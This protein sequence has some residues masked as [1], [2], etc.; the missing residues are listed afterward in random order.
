MDVFNDE[1]YVEINMNGTNWI[2]LAHVKRLHH[3]TQTQI[4]S[5]DKETVIAAA[6]KMADMWGVPVI[7]DN[8]TW[9]K[10]AHNTE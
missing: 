8:N 4:A 1:R 6:T 5:G 10:I 9:R 7:M 3:K 2:A